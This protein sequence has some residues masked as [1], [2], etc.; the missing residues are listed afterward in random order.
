MATEPRVCYEL[1]EWHWI[2]AY[3]HHGFVKQT[4]NENMFEVLRPNDDGPI[5]RHYLVDDDGNP[6]GDPPA[7]VL[8]MSPLPL[9]ELLKRKPEPEPEPEPYI[10]ANEF[11]DRLFYMLKYEN[12]EM[13]RLKYEIE[14]LHR[15]R[16]ES[17]AF[18]DLSVPPLTPEHE[19]PYMQE[20][21]KEVRQTH[22]QA[23]G[24]Q[25]GLAIFEATKKHLAAKEMA[26]QKIAMLP[27]HVQDQRRQAPT[28]QK[29]SNVNTTAAPN[30]VIVIDDSPIEAHAA[31]ALPTQ[32]PPSAIVNPQDLAVQSQLALEEQRRQQQ[33]KAASRPSVQNTQRA[34]HALQRPL[35]A[36]RAATP[37]NAA[38]TMRHVAATTPNAPQK[39]MKNV[40]QN[41]LRPQS[42]S[43]APAVG[44][45]SARAYRGQ[46]RGVPHALHRSQAIDPRRFEEMRQMYAQQ[47]PQSTQAQVPVM[48]TAMPGAS[49]AGRQYISQTPAVP[50]AAPD[51]SSR[52]QSRRQHIRHQQ[53][54]SVSG[55]QTCINPQDLLR[56]PQQQNTPQVPRHINPSVALQQMEAS[57]QLQV[58]GEQQTPSMRGTRISTGAQTPVMYQKNQ[59][60]NAAAGKTPMMH[61]DAAFT[62]RQT[63]AMPQNIAAMGRQ[64]PVAKRDAA[65]MEQQTPSKRQKTSS[66]AWQT[67]MMRQNMAGMGQQTP[68]R[69]QMPL[70]PTT[71]NGR[72]MAMLPH[73]ANHAPAMQQQMMQ[74]HTQAMQKKLSV[75]HQTPTKTPMMGQEMPPV[76]QQMPNGQ[77]T[78]TKTPAMQHQVLSAG[79]QMPAGQCTPAKAPAVQ[80]GTPAMEKQMPT[81][82]QTPITQR[83]TQAMWQQ[84]T[85]GQQLQMMQQYRNA[86]MQQQMTT[87]QQTSILQDQMPVNQ[88]QMITHMMMRRRIQAQQQAMNLGQQVPVTQQH[89]VPVMPQQAP[90]GQH[91]P[92]T[93]QEREAYRQMM[94]HRNRTQ[95]K[96]Q[97][98]HQ[99]Q[100]QQQP[101]PIYQP[102]PQ[103]PQMSGDE[104]LTQLFPGLE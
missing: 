101:Q 48:P 8:A 31:L 96:Q 76:R 85:T 56:A 61:R 2:E 87:S 27:V 24:W 72:Q 66:T 70:G 28:K 53:S 7:E 3:L 90:N 51:M 34:P 44:A 75:G 54:Q 65:Q 80:H 49:Q 1:V 41:N 81:G 22:P 63:S 19:P 9:S 32:F 50:A 42:R 68:T 95:Q 43:S 64:T 40:P 18:H 47:Q 79:N 33:A 58:V 83:Q 35:P 17:M 36:V 20:V 78:P 13:D 86:A 99:Q 25:L 26:N 37:K 60:M 55:L 38:V 89:Q 39:T 94:I 97:N 82:Q 73:Q 15:A 30:E 74:R 11:E 84:M 104:I 69:K 67:P 93:A 21:R 57:R 92:I 102:Q 88:E 45:A 98:R 59:K 5:L 6:V 77:Q 16:P 100:C 4:E 23:R 29:V 52:P 91:R 62:G 14:E 12:E 10:K 71:P 46:A 103:P